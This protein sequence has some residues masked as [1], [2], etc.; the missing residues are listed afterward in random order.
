MLFRSLSGGRAFFPESAG[1]L[2]DTLGRIALELRHQ[3][4]IGF[5]PSDLA[6]AGQWRHLKVKV[7]PPPGLAAL[8][9]RSREGYLGRNLNSPEK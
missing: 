3:Y 7:N 9:V 2:E 8:I 4:T 5:Y 6:A 1:E